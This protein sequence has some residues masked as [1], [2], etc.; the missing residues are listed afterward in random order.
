MLD[1]NMWWAK[2]KKKKKKPDK[3]AFFIDLSKAGTPDNQH[4][5][6]ASYIWCFK[7]DVGIGCTYLS[8]LLF[9]FWACRMCIDLKVTQF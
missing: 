9:V 4:Y 3:G 8:M 6:L 2:K 5:V 7:F 1:S